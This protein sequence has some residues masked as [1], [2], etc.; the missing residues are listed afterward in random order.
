MD[1]KKLF[2]TIDRL[3]QRYM[4]V[5]QDICNIE[6]PGEYKE[7]VDKVGEYIAGIAEGFGW[8]VERLVQQ[9]SG[10]VICI[11]M[12]P[13]SHQSP[14]TLSAHIDTVHPIGSFGYPP[15]RIDGD[16]IYGP[17]VMDCKGGAAAALMAMEALSIC[18]FSL[19]PVRLILQ[20]DEECSSA[21]SD[22]EN[23]EYICRKSADSVAFLNCEGYI[24]GTAVLTRKGI[25]K[26][27]FSV[28]GKSA[29]ASRCSLGANAIAEAAHKILE[30]E[31]FKD[32]NG[33]TCSCGIISGGT[34]SNTV[35]DSCEFYVDVRFSTANEC[36]KIKGIIS[37]IA[38]KSF[39]DGCV[40]EAVL[41]S[42]RPAM[43]SSEKNCVLL[44]RMNEIF[45]ENG[46]ELL[47]ARK[48]AGGSD[49]AEVTVA[50]IPCVDSIGVEGDHIHTPREYAVLSSLAAAAKRLAV[51]TCFI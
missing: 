37:E 13:S 28:K 40:T 42:F 44:Q 30:L 51:V 35:P 26:Y 5:W 21:L 27:H 33:I 18:G 39:V 1:S 41:E 8:Q 16:Y 15:V 3:N 45:A 47:T 6:S 38:D 7:G 50:G 11:T 9:R 20:T 22:K 43:E 29:H 2:E 31:K 12:N 32:E 19:R 25:L 36:E 4:S 34:A 23:I 49:A 17:G 46:L 10:N 14:V 24:K 48:S